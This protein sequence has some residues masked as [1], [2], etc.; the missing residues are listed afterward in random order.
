MEVIV[1]SS[2]SIFEWRESTVEIK[3]VTR[4]IIEYLMSPLVRYRQESCT[5]DKLLIFT[6]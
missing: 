4:R 5:K 6:K 3:T 2:S 1:A